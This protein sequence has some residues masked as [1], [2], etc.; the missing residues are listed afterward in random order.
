[1]I[2]RMLGFALAGW[3]SLSILWPCFLGGAQS[4]VAA[5]LAAASCEDLGAPVIPLESRAAA[6]EDKL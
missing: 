3:A 5:T 2:A 1:M 6:D 4:S